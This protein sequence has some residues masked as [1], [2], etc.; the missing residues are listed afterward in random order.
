MPDIT[1]CKNETCPRKAECFRYTVPYTSYQTWTV[2]D[3]KKDLCFWSNGK[4]KD[5]K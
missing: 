3:W 4:G 1:M 2:F 5:G